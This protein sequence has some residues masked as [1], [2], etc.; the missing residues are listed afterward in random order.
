[1]AITVTMI[2]EK[3]FKTRVRGYDP[4]EVDE[5]LDAI[6]D[7]MVSM[8]QTIQQL[9][10][11]LKQQQQQS[12]APYMPAAP[13]P[14]APIAPI[15]PISAPSPEP[16]L[17]SDL[18]SAKLLLE[19]TQSACDEVIAKA[20]ERAEEIIKSAEESLPDPELDSLE[21]RKEELKKEI[22]AL[23]IDAQKFKQRFQTMLKD[24]IDI[25]DS[26]LS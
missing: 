14:I 7:E 6:V 26:E 15:S 3:E 17:P 21:A 20:K 18:K 24:Q 12:P 10:D 23:E 16:S 9:R 22:E 25:L 4:L 5:F 2:E 1:M 8:G 13:A 19:K 11:Q